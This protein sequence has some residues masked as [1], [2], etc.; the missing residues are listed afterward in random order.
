MPVENGAGTTTCQTSHRGLL[1]V[2]DRVHAR[3]TQLRRILWPRD[4]DRFRLQY[5]TALRALRLDLVFVDDVDMVRL[6]L[7]ASSM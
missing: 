2:P 6:G 5:E 7:T 1:G 3:R 4:A